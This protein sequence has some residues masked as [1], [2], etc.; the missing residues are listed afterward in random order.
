MVH[1]SASCFSRLSVCST[2]PTSCVWSRPPRLRPGVRSVLLLSVLAV[3]RKADCSMPAPSV[4]C[5]AK[6]RMKIVT[7]TCQDSKRKNLAHIFPLHGDFS[8]PPFPP[9]LFSFFFF[10]VLFGKGNPHVYTLKSKMHKWSVHNS[11]T[12]EHLWAWVFLG[13]QQRPEL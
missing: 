13:N 3:Q 5:L 10:F 6:A 11:V 7:L 9:S 2:Q 1:L 12:R 4:Q 8:S